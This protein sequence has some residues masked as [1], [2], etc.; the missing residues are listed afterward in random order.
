MRRQKNEITW[1]N[2]LLYLLFSVIILF[3]LSQT[4]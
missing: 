1:Q 2:E 3:S 4:F